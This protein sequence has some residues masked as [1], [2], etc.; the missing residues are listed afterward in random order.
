VSVDGAAAA[1]EKGSSGV[2]QEAAAARLA[3]L[4]S[5]EAIDRMLADAEASE[6]PLDGPDGLICRASDFVAGLLCRSERGV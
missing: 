1:A 5:D 2:G 6:T 4:V 3:E